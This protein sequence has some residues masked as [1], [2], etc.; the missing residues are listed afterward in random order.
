MGN[1]SDNMEIFD[2][3]SSYDVGN[4]EIH[5]SSNHSCCNRNDAKAFV[6]TEEG[7]GKTHVY[8]YKDL[9]RARS[10]F[11]SFVCCRKLVDSDG[12]VLEDNGR[13]AGHTIDEAI[14]HLF[15]NCL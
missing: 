6:V 12:K 4:F 3:W 5:E 13:Q 2:H 11:N 9:V 7:I 15:L 1:Q 14:G 10:I 8:C